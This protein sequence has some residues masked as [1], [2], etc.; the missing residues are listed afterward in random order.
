MSNSANRPVK[1]TLCRYFASDGK[2]FFGESCQYVHAKPAG[3]TQSGD[4]SFTILPSTSGYPSGEAAN[5]YA[6]GNT[7]PNALTKNF[8][9]LSIN[10]LEVS[11]QP[12]NL[13]NPLSP[14]GSNTSRRPSAN[15]GFE[16]LPTATNHAIQS[17][18]IGGT[19]FF[20]P[21]SQPAE[22][23]I[24]LPSYHVYP[25]TPSHLANLQTSSKPMAN[26]FFISSQIRQDLLNQHSATLAQLNPDDTSIPREVESYNSLVPLE[27]IDSIANQQSRRTFGCITTCYKCVSSKD[28]LTYVLRKMHGIRLTNTKAKGIVD[29]WKK[30]Q[31]SNLVHLREMFTTKT[32]DDNSLVFVYDYHPGA[33]TILQ[34]HFSESLTGLMNIKDG[35][36]G[37]VHQQLPPGRKMF[38]PGSTASGRQQFMAERLIWNYIIQLSSALRSI[39]SLMLACRV[40]E[41]SKILV[42]SNSRLR[43]NGCG[44]FD[45]LDSN[46]STSMVQHYQQEDLVSFGRLIL[47]LACCSLQAVNRENIQQS[48]EIISL[49]YSNDLKNLILYL[50]R[51][52]PPNHIKSIND[53]MPMI[54]A[55]FYTQL[56]AAQLRCDVLQGELAKEME[57][58]RLFRLLCKMGSINER[59]EFNMDPSWSETGDRYLIKLF[60]D[61]LFHQVTETG[62]PWLDM[63]HIVSSLNKL[64]CGSPEKICL[65]SRDEQ[66]VLVVSYHDL[67]ACF[68]GA[69]NELSTLSS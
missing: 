45:V 69:F 52:P 10:A 43:I 67:K 35:Q 12:Q 1:A 20:Y 19:T 21:D 26:S 68:D 59:P 64:D 34:R 9:G 44:I 38:T 37:V 14:K 49:K 6:T 28:G 54:G 8:S 25:S 24:I 33:E 60:R 29:E 53:V 22:P 61:Y 39:H 4:K 40:I 13:A 55:R 62:E 65:I 66:S 50:L 63:S 46:N 3:N 56:D 31:H 48:M 23:S 7:E 15:Q 32:F 16:F 27:P 41:P 57:N 11:E 18:S 42:L 51:Q 36:N 2:C 47:M 30:L 5:K 58:S 17:E